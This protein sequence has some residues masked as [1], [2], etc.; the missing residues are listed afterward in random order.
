VISIHLVVLAFVCDFTNFLGIIGHI[1]LDVKLLG[2][3]FPAPFPET[4]FGVNKVSN[5][6]RCFCYVLIQNTH[7]LISSFVPLVVGDDLVKS[8]GS[9]SRVI[10]TRD[11]VPANASIC[12]MI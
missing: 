6:T 3:L 10:K 5:L 9:G 1:V 7:V 11:Y 4:K 2:S 12:N 8:H